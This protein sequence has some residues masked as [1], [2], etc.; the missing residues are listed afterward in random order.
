VSF[1]AW[2][3]LGCLSVYLWSERYGELA[4]RERLT[5]LRKRV[6]YAR[7]FK[8]LL[9]LKIPP[10]QWPEVEPSG[11]SWIICRLSK[12]VEYSLDVGW[13]QAC[14]RKPRVPGAGSVGIETAE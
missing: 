8:H 7:E 10:M 6:V 1:S 12:W 9:P 14:V 11:H 5:I 13:F 4:E 3:I 2:N